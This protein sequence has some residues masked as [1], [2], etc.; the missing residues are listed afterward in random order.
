VI[1]LAAAA[2]LVAAR[3]FAQGPPAGKG[4]GP[5]WDQDAEQSFHMGRG[6][7]RRLM[8]ED[9]WKEHRAKMRGMTAEDRSRYREAMH[10]RMME[11]AKEK[12]VTVPDSPGPRGPK[13]PGPR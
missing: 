5:R 7:G 10:K 8:T 3:G 12:G 4:P 13:G 6:M 11:R 2:S 9:E 1:G